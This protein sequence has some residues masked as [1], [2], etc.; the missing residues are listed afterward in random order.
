MCGV[1]VPSDVTNTVEVQRCSDDLFLL[2]LQKEHHCAAFIPLL[3][4]SEGQHLHSWAEYPRGQLRKPE[5]VFG[6]RSSGVWHTH[7]HKVHDNEIQALWKET[8]WEHSFKLMATNEMYG[9]ECNFQCLLART[10]QQ[11]L[12]LPV[13]I[14]TIQSAVESSEANLNRWYETSVFVIRVVCFSLLP[15]L[16]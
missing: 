2:W 10:E 5:E 7:T 3:W 15:S 6:G 13:E 8:W 1:A 16:F 14:S 11:S 9:L 12:T 4:A